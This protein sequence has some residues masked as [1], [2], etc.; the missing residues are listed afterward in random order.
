MHID[1]HHNKDK[2]WKESV[3]VF[4]GGSL[5]FLDSELSGEVTDILSTEITETTTKKAY[6]DNLLKISASGGKVTGVHP[7]WEAQVSLS[8]IKRFASY[9]ID[10]SR[11]HDIDFTT[12]I[13]TTQKPSVT[14]YKSPS[15]AFTPKIINLKERDADKELLEI[16][17][18]LKANENINELLLIY[19]PLYGSESGKTTVE[20][21]DTAIKLTSEVAKDDKLKLGK[22]QSLMILL[23]STFI[24]DEELQ[25]VLEANRMVLE[26]N[27][28][29]RVL[30]NMGR[31]QE[32]IDIAKNMLKE[33]EDITKISRFTQLEISRIIELQSELQIKEA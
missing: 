31:G 17:R 18:K 29:V 33:G 26:D 28:A 3:E 30:S 22:L 16:D 2:V 13:I 14:C 12:V 10:H 20:L 5:E 1:T 27:R 11:M 8:D 25:K 24:S 4:K 19:L 23:N 15:M 9:H 21:L 32:K 6:S 7:E